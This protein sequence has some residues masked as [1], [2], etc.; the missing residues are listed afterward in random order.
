ML[1]LSQPILRP[2]RE[3]TL[4]G[5]QDF[6]SA[7]R[8]LASGVCVITAGTQAGGRSGLTATSVTSLAANPASL[9]VCVNRAS[10]TF[11]LIQREGVFGVN[12]LGAVHQ[13][14]AER[15]SGKG[16]TK[17][18]DRYRDAQ[19]TT[20]ATGAPILED[21]LA[22]LDCTVDE[23]IVRHSH[24]IVIGRVRAIRCTEKHESLLYWR[25]GYQS[26][27]GG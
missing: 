20:L 21:A 17:G 9:L 11:P 23:I 26:T 25:A 19:W 27:N 24:G 2:G 1:A 22:A 18:E 3:A 6:R 16:G 5:P 12:I 15:F 13:E 7:M 14:V 4:V 8:E 10:S